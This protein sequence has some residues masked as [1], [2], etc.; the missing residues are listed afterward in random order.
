MK[1]VDRVLQDWRIK[2]AAKYIPANSKV[3][4]IGSFQGE[5]CD[6]CEKISE[7]WGVDPK[8]ESTVSSGRK[9][10]VRGFFPQALPD[11]KNFD[12]VTML[13]VLEHVPT[14]QQHEL[15]QAIAASLKSGGRVIITVPSAIVDAIL[16]VLRLL[17]IIDGMSLEEHYGF[18]VEDTVRLFESVGLRMM[19]RS[20]FQLGCN[21]LFVFENTSP[22][23]VRA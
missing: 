15:A 6:R 8:V 18:K 19:H 4:D 7:Y 22:E 20:K 16:A 13:A 9:R 21:N 5:L 14:K 11:Q 23:C 1:W 10:L 12:A 17:R 3:L 2:K